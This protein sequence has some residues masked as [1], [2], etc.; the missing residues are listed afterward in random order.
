[1]FPPFPIVLCGVNRG[2]FTLSGLLALFAKLSGSSHCKKDVNL[3]IIPF[4]QSNLTHIINCS[5]P[6][7]QSNL[8]H[9][10]NCSMFSLQLLDGTGFPLLTRFSYKTD[11]YLTRVFSGP[12]TVLIFYLTR[13]FLRN[14][15]PCQNNHQIFF[16]SKIASKS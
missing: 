3:I 5:I 8:T 11:F 13:L 14:S 12:K 15:K 16:S 6:F 2:A 9:I 7:N 4:N 1:M 10:R